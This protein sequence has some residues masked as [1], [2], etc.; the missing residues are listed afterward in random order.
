MKRVL[1][2]AG[3][4]AGALIAQQALADAVAHLLNS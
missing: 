4:C 3:L 2:L 1:R